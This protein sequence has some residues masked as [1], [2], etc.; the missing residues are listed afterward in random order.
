M[1]PES[2]GP[3]SAMAWVHNN[4]Y[5]LGSSRSPQESTDN[6]IQLMQKALALDD[7]NAEFHAALCVFYTYK[8]EYDKAIAEGDR[9]LVLNPGGTS[10][11]FNYAGSL[12]YAGRPEEAIPL[13]QRAIRLN[14]FAPSPTF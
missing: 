2:P 3:Y 6:A 9:A 8:R 5:W 10:V 11:L 1:C 4:E 12:T 13:L 14:P 7:S